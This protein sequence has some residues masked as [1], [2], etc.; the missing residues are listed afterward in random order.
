[1]DKGQAEIQEQVERLSEASQRSDRRAQPRHRPLSLAYVTVGDNN[2]GIVVDVSEDGLQL[3][4]AE[5]LMTG[6]DLRLCIRPSN[7]PDPIVVVGRVVWLSQSRKS[8]GFYFVSPSEQARQQIRRWIAHELRGTQDVPRAVA[9]PI[10]PPARTDVPRRRVWAP[11][12]T[13]SEKSETTKPDATANASSRL[14]PPSSPVPAP[15]IV[16]RTEPAATENGSLPPSNRDPE[17]VAEVPQERTVET[18]APVIAPTTSKPVEAPTFSE[19]EH[20]LTKNV[21]E[22]KVPIEAAKGFRPAGTPANLPLNGSTNAWIPK[23]GTLFAS[24]NEQ[25]KIPAQPAA[26]IS[27][28]WWTPL[29]LGILCAV[30]VILCLSAGMLTG[31]FM[32]GK[33]MWSRLT[34]LIHSNASARIE[35]ATSQP[36]Q[37]APPADN[38]TQNSPDNVAPNSGTQ[39]SAG[40]A[41]GEATPKP[42]TA[43]PF[44][45]NPSINSSPQVPAEP[46]TPEPTL[47]SDTTAY[48]TPPGEDQEPA[49]IAFPQEA[50]T[51]SASIAVGM[52]RSVLIAPEPGSA[53]QHRRK[54]LVM[55]KI[56]APPPP[57][58]LLPDVAN[59]ANQGARV[60]LRVTIGETGDIETM[61][62]IDGPRSL[63]PTAENIVTDWHQEPARLDGKAIE[64]F[65]NITVSFRP[66]E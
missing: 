53:S 24:S 59:A 5:A 3:V 15:E 39:P 28:G 57:S 10:P 58:E 49:L 7:P 22:E 9:E 47:D 41:N 2:G 40:T 21:S 36:Q 33:Q 63:V 14:E 46:P 12:P 50:V 61:T 51:A 6:E 4:A 13:V 27:E 1:M 64:S 8:A 19:E 43:A 42:S 30:I 56:D 60:R 65:E 20:P 52:T 66:R 35:N 31:R 17:K 54:R 32:T 18:P 23:G 38:S 16:A 26:T 45:Q 25:V 11:E 48:I 62:A 37:P 55:G 34:G 44:D 29:N